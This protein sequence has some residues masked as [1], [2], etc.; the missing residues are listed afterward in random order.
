MRCVKSAFTL[1]EIVVTIVILGVLVTVALPNFNNHMRR[2][3]TREA[4]VILKAVYAAQK[5][6]RLNNPNYAD[7]I[8]LLDVQLSRTPKYF[9]SPDLTCIESPAFVLAYV[10]STDA[11]MPG[12]YINEQGGVNCF[13]SSLASCSF[14][15][16]GRCSGL[17]YPTNTIWGE[18][19]TAVTG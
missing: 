12:F 2:I 6:Y 10:N 17:D 7:D 4:E 9:S 5:E 11:S 8:N 15:D 16:G 1:T 19:K 13:D 3:K 14:G 18:Q